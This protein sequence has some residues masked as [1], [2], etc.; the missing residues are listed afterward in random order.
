MTIAITLIIVT[1]AALLIIPS[2]KKPPITKF[3]DRIITFINGKFC[4][5]DAR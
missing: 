2:K 4:L 5:K 1:I 3:D